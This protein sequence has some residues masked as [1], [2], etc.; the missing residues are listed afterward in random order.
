MNQCHFRASEYLSR[1]KDENDK[2]SHDQNADSTVTTK[3]P[4]LTVRRSTRV[5]QLSSPLS[6]LGKNNVVPDALSHLDRND[7]AFANVVS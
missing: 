6:K 2:D 5:K 1:F 3:A 7:E 4:T